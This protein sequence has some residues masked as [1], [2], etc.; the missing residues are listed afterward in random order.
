MITKILVAVDGSVTADRA[1][2]GVGAD[3]VILTV[4]PQ[5]PTSLFGGGPVEMD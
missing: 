3:V 5:T 2:E 1:L 4:V